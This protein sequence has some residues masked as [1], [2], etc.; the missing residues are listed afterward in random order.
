VQLAKL[1]TETGRAP[2]ALEIITPLAGVDADA[3]VLNAYGIAL[4]EGGRLREAV[5]Q[6]QKAIALDPNNAPAYENLGIT[7]LRANDVRGA[8]ENLTRALQL[9]PRLPL[10]LN[11]L[12]VV[13]IRKGDSAR[14]QEAWKQSF[15]IDRRQ[16]DALY[17]LGILAARRGD[18]EEARRALAEFVRIAPPAR[19]SADI[20]AAKRALEALR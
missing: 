13:Y 17:N 7:A 20:A 3:D 11:T 8:E 10:A 19:Y 1:L 5:A 9:N 2:E 4:S 16:Y 14:A 18:R 15:T 6:F 12:G